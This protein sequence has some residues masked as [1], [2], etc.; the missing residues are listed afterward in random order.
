MEKK[1]FCIIHN[2]GNILKAVLF[3]DFFG[4]VDSLWAVGQFRDT[5]ISNHIGT[6]PVLL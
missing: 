6:K 4:L 3:T 2:I 1:C 5:D